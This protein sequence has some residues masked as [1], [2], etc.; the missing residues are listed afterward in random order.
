[1]YMLK[2]IQLATIPNRGL[3]GFPES[4]SQTQALDIERTQGTRNNH[5]CLTT[6]F[7][8]LGMHKMNQRF[9]NSRPCRT[10]AAMI[11]VGLRGAPD[12]AY[13]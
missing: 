1:M 8:K 11:Q 12:P 6:N 3:K 4:S 7:R 5:A 13:L 2:S 9:P 10:A